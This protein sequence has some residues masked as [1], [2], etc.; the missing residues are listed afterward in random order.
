MLPYAT[1]ALLS[2]PGEFDGTISNT[3]YIVLEPSTCSVD[4]SLLV[5]SYLTYKAQI[6][7]VAIRCTLFKIHHVSSIF[8]ISWLL[9]VD[10]NS[11]AK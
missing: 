4:I 1:G 6:S 8:K 3:S 11:V 10:F 5:V 7:S 9:S 2:P